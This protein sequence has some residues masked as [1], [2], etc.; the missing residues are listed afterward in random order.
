MGRTYRRGGHES[1]HSYKSGNVKRKGSQRSKPDYSET[2]YDK[3]KVKY[4]KQSGG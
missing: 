3:P 4:P 1:T 2:R